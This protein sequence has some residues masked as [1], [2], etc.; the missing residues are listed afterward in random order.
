V[1]AAGFEPAAWS[2][3]RVRSACWTGGSGRHPPLE[4]AKEDGKSTA[5]ALFLY[6]LRLQADVKWACKGLDLQRADLLA[7]LRT[8]D[9]AWKNSGSR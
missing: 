3:W 7:L 4:K 6:Q 5:H 1:E 2:F 8:V 9:T